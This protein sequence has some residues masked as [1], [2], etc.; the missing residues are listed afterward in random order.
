L[1]VTIP[2]ERQGAAAGRATQTAR[3]G[4]TGSSGRFAGDLFVE[5]RPPGATVFM[6]GKAVGTTPLTLRAVTAG[7]HVV[8]LEHEGY[9][10][11]SSA[12]R[13]VASQAN[14]ITASLER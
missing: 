6:D 7:S 2:L 14:R 12:V 10:R 5:S 9:R 13:V 3:T 4:E 8:R 11:W 1:S